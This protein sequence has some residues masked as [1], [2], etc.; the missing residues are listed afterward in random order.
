MGTKNELSDQCLLEVGQLIDLLE[1]F[2]GLGC[3]E[4]VLVRDSGAI[5]TVK[6]FDYLWE[7]RLLGDR[8]L[9]LFHVGFFDLPRL[10]LS[11]FGIF[12]IF[13]FSLN[14]LLMFHFGGGFKIGQLIPDLEELATEALR[15]KLKLLARQGQEEA[16]GPVDLGKFKVENSGVILALF[17]NFGLTNSLPIHKF[18]DHRL[19]KVKLR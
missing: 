11:F 12:K 13:S 7:E 15:D 9:D 6:Q 19:E 1:A 8:G 14:N 2:E 5:G 17:D 16:E 10:I 18:V 3:L 4:E